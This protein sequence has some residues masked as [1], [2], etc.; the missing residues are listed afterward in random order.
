MLFADMHGSPWRSW[1]ANEMLHSRN[2]I[3]FLLNGLREMGWI[4]LCSADVS[5]KYHSDKNDSKLSTC[6]FKLLCMKSN[7]YLRLFAG[8]SFYIPD[9]TRYDCESFNRYVCTVSASR[10]SSVIFLTVR[11]KLI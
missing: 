3:M 7:E 9:K 4:M 2:M 6:I 1:N 8:L 10:H 11:T 5:A